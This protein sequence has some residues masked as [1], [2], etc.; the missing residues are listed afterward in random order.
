MNKT[1]KHEPNPMTGHTFGPD[2]IGS[3][4]T[5]SDTIGPVPAEGGE[6]ARGDVCERCGEEHYR[7]P[8]GAMREQCTRLD[9]IEAR[10]AAIERHLGFFNIQVVMPPETTCAKEGMT[11]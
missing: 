7:T 9:M 2:T 1:T 11:W 10:I 3:D 6:L 4:K 8:T 5:C